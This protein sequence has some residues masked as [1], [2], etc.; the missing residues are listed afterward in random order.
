MAPG[1][2]RRDRAAASASAEVLTPPC[3]EVLRRPYGDG[4]AQATGERLAD[5]LT[6]TGRA[7]HVTRLDGL[8]GVDGEG[9]PAGGADEVERGHDLDY[10]EGA[11]VRNRGADP[12]PTVAAG[13]GRVL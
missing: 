12:P 10:P 9:T 4:V 3:F 11:P 13:L 6:T 5:G 2:V 7:A 1:F 8:L